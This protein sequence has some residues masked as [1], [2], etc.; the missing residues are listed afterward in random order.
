MTVGDDKA[1]DEIQVLAKYYG[2]DENGDG[3]YYDWHHA[4]H[5]DNI[6][7]H[8]GTDSSAPWE[9]T[10]NTD[11][12]PDQ[13]PESV[14]L[15]ARIRDTSGIWFVAPVIDEITLERPA[16]MSVKMYTS[17]R[18]PEKFT[19][20]NHAF[21]SCYIHIDELENAQEAKLFHRTWN[22]SDTEASRGQI[23]EPLIVNKHGFKCFGENHYYALSG[24]DI[25]VS[26][27]DMGE[28]EVSYTS[29]TEHHGIEIL[30]P[31]PTIIIRYEN[32][33]Q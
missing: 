32:Y 7:D 4:Y 24:V 15:M 25:H 30:W 33:E 26:D 2:Y 22:G 14:S 6:E 18:I 17:Y 11:W 28:I 9:I 19:V 27:L 13:K 3:Y 5:I 31:G 8:A 16:G 21:K 10:W 12:V 23:E 29:D 1:V 20:R